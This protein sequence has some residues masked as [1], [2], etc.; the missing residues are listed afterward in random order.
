MIKSSA[1]LVTTGHSPHVFLLSLG[2][3][4]VSRLFPDDIK[5][6]R[7]TASGDIEHASSQPPIVLSGWQYYPL[8]FP[9]RWNDKKIASNAF[10]HDGVINSGGYHKFGYNLPL[11]YVIDGCFHE[12]DVGRLKFPIIGSC[13]VRARRSRD[14]RNQVC[15]NTNEGA[16]Y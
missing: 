6:K 14:T 9:V 1:I 13:S 8:S 16:W 12:F 11:A 3:R 10:A 5:Q 7:L 15:W 4:E 2:V